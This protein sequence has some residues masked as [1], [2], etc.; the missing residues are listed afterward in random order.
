[1]LEPDPVGLDVETTGLDPRANRVRLLSLA[2]PGGD[3]GSPTTFLIDCFAVEPS[4]LWGALA[5]KP[6]IMHNAAFDLGFLTRLG[7]EPGAVTD[8]MLLSQL[9]DGTRRPKGYHGLRE[10]VRRELGQDIDKDLQSSDWSRELTPEQLNYAAADAAILLPLHTSLMRRIQAAGLERVAEIEMRCLPAMVWTASHGVAFD[11]ERWRSL[12]A[13]AQSE[14][15]RLA[16]ELDRLSPRPEQGELFGGGWNWDSPA[17]VQAVFA[18]LGITLDSTDDAVLAA[19]DHPLAALLR[20]YRAARKGCT[21][22]GLPWLKHVAEDGRV[23]AS[24]RQLGAD[25]GRMA[26]RAPN[27]QNLPKDDGCRGCVVAP[28][29]RVL[30]KADY[31]QIELRI[32]AK[33]AGEQRMLDAYRRGDDLHTLTARQ[34]TGKDSISK[35]DRKLAKAV[36]FGLL[37]GMGAKGFLVYAKSNYGVDL[38]EDE[39]ARYRAAF[40]DAYPSLRRWHRSIRDGEV[41][42][43]TLAGRRRSGIT[44]FTEKLNT[45]VQGTGAD[46]LKTALAL[47]WERRAEVPGAFPVLAVHDEVVVECDEH[48]ADAVSA[49]LKRAMQD[50]MQPLIDPVPVEVEVTVGR[51][52]AGD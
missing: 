15:E 20:Q 26:C 37:Y 3:D 36:N 10:V 52:W 30:V 42:T 2:V 4:P 31:S 44:R 1:L 33:V 11:A 14:S 19:V 23:Y 8:T 27:L 48:Q 7:F 24:W 17:Q 21:T 9:L 6:L 28:P 49:W 41:E 46:G 22:Y 45:P 16:G 50:G 25:S 5:D 51:T 29:G 13:K 35:D 40:F 38:T 34:V 12:A 32:A 47:M 39:A 43:R 18:R